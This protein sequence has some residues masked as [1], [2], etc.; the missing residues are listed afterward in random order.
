MDCTNFMKMIIMVVEICGVFWEALI[1]GV[2]VLWCV[3][4][5]LEFV[6]LES[7]WLLLRWEGRAR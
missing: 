7:C 2:S 4:E 1:E 6:Y 5:V 3:V